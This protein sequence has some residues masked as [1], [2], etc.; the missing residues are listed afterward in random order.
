MLLQDGGA[1]NGVVN[2]PRRRSVV[3]VAMVLGHLGK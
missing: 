1:M 2:G 3:G